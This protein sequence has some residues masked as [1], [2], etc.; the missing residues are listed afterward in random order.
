MAIGTTEDIDAK[1]AVREIHRAKRRVSLAEKIMAD[2]K[3]TY[4]QAKAEREQA[5]SDLL[6]AI[7]EQA[8]PFL[9]FESR[10]D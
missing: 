2:A 3:A 1:P 10:K 6:S 4:K 7:E 9:P 5:L 8:E